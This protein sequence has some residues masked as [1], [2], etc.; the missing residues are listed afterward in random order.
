MRPRAR[1]LPGNFGGKRYSF[2]PLSEWGLG[3]RGSQWREKVR[4]KH[5]NSGG[6][7]GKRKGV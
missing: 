6:L 5:K 7:A 4:D 2:R 3:L 1:A